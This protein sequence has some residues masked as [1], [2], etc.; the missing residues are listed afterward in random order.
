[1]DVIGRLMGSRR[2]FGGVYP[3][4]TVS[5]PLIGSTSYVLEDPDPSNLYRMCKVQKPM[6]LK[7]P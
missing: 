3:G 5:S 2:V 6:R 7:R 1:M 4:V